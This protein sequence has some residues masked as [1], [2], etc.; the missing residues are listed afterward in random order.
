MDE[1]YARIHPDDRD[2]VYDWELY[3]PKSGRIPELIIQLA[4]AGMR[5]ADIEARVEAAL[6]DALAER[7]NDG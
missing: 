4:Q 6:Q 3:G 1:G 2:A 7:E 5:L